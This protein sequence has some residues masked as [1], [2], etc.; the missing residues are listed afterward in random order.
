[1]KGFIAATPFFFVYGIKV[2]IPMEFKVPT[3]QSELSEGMDHEKM[4]RQKLLLVEERCDI[5][6]IHLKAYHQRL[7]QYFKARVKERNFK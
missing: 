2:V 7:K 4:L 3:L 5:V 6:A 1:M